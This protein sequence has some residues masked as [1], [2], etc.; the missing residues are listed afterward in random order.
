[1]PTK[2]MPAKG[3]PTRPETYAD[4][5]ASINAALTASGVANNPIVLDRDVTISPLTDIQGVERMPIAWLLYE[6]G[7]KMFYITNVPM[8]THI[9]PHTHSEDV[10]RYILSG[11]LVVNAN[12]ESFRITQGMWFVIKKNISY[13]VKTDEGYTALAAYRYMCEVKRD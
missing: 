10:F 12:N 7:H 5:K 4:Y 6:R 3:M 1:M 13:E 11:S 2:D 8:G 9:K